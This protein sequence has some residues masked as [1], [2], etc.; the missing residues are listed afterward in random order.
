MEIVPV[1]DLLG[2][3]CVRLIQ[4]RYDRVIDY[5]SDPLDVARQF[6]AAGATWLHVVDLDGARNG[7]IENLAGVVIGRA[8]YEH[9]IDLKEA[10]AAV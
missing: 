2:G 1:L 4:G 6:R 5:E 9:A 10:L 8:L 7:T 3:K